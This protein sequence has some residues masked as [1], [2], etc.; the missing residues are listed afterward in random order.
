MNELQMTTARDTSGIVA[1]Q[2]MTQ[3][4][5]PDERVIATRFGDVT[6]RPD[7]PV[8]FPQGLL[9]FPDCSR[10]CL[11]SFPIKKFERFRLLQSLENDELSF[12]VLPLELDN[13]ILARQ[14]LLEAA[15][16]LL[17]PEASLRIMLVVSVHRLETHVRLSVNSRAPILMDRATG[18]ASQH[19]FRD[20]R[21]SIQHYIS[22]QISDRI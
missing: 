13:P 22:G 7:E 5:V 6:L 8:M 11:L 17:I 16:E 18:Q 9:G 15:Q 12:I 10:F 1:S 21:Y 4:S 14:D 2:M 20:S 3:E 19:V